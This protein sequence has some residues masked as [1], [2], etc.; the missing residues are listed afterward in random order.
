MFSILLK[1]KRRI[2]KLLKVQ[3]ETR[4]RP[5]ATIQSRTVKV[6]LLVLIS[7]LV[8]L[9]YPYQSLYDPLDMPREGEIAL[10]DVI[11][12]FQIT[13]L[14][15][16]REVRDEVEETRLSEPHVIDYDTTIV[17]SAFTRMDQFFALVDSLQAATV[18][19]DTAHAGDFPV[20]VSQRF[21]LLSKT[22]VEKSFEQDS[23]PKIH[24]DLKKILQDEIYQIGVLPDGYSLPESR[25]RS[26]LV[27]RG[28][29]QNIISRDK[30]YPVAMAYPRLLTALN[31]LSASDSIDVDYYYKIGLGFIQPNLRVNLVE[32][33]RRIDEALASVSQIK[34]IV[35]KNEIILR[36][37]QRV[38][39]DQE[40]VLR[41][42]ARSLR[43]EAADQPWLSTILPP[44]ARV[45]LVLAAFSALYLFLFFFRRDMFRSN[46]KLLALFLVFA[47]QLFLVY[48]L[49]V[50]LELS[51]YL[52]P[53]ALLPIMVTILFDAEVGILSTVV[54]AFLLGIMHRFDFALTFMTVAVGTVAC[55]TARQV[56]RRTEFFRIMYSTALAFAAYAVMIETLKLTPN[57]DVLTEVGYGLINGIVTSL[58]AIGVLPFFESLFGI[59]TDI[60][61]LELSNPNHPLLKR[62]ALEAPGTYHHSVIVG[63]LTE[64]A[65]AAIGANALLARVGAFFHD[66]GKI[67][68]P[69]YFVENQLSV[70][71]K[72]DELTPSM[73]SIILSSH[74][75]MGRQLG[76]EAGLPDDVLNFVEE[77]HGTMV[78]SYFY[79]KALEQGTDEDNVDKFRYPGPKPQTRETGIAMLAD[80]IE[81]A[82]RT[83][84][85]PKPA[86]ITHLI[87][88]IINERFQSGELDQCPLTLRDLAKIREAFA[89]VLI[90]TFHHRVVYPK[91]DKSEGE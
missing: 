35:D 77:H 38:S 81:A 18:P 13:V 26:V 45:I 63:N 89:Q 47:L 43:E 24:A 78:Q 73:S 32:Y 27:R 46:P 33:E 57:P 6:L 53:V 14:K 10:E 65:A 20:I 68:I 86:R 44:L 50:R 69:E 76:E 62:L 56:R 64:A 22:A 42:M 84:D 39:E 60:T 19:D 83:L 28:D 48:L 72:H 15:T 9:L 75:K 23:L 80:A 91:K 31:R 74:V 52:Y 54:L 3:S 59:S 25:N 30:L 66:I 67:E 34:K 4:Q 70:K 21:P 90:G 61:L 40:R 37:G 49:G 71:S 5:Q 1:I 17:S 7:L 12:P 58:L 79:N 87:Q 51:I 2:K 85:D 41:E 11:A 29:R 82:S 36:A 55:L 16:D 8:G 88:R